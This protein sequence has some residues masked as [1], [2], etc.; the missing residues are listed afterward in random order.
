MDSELIEVN[1]FLNRFNS[2]KIIVDTNNL[3]NNLP[4]AEAGKKNFDWVIINP[5]TYTGMNATPS[6]VFLSFFPRRFN[7]A[8]DVFSSCSFIPPA[9]FLRQVY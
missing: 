6:E 4:K 2:Y 7:I 8:P 9:H 1:F 3:S 5:P